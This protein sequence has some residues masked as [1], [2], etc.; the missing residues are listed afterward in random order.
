MEQTITPAQVAASSAATTYTPFRQPQ[1]HPASDALDHDTNTCWQGRD[2][3]P[4]LEM[5]LPHTLFR[6]RVVS[7]EP[8]VAGGAAAAETEAATPTPTEAPA[9]HGLTS[10]ELSASST[11]SGDA[12]GREPSDWYPLRPVVQSFERVPC[13][14]P[15]YDASKPGACASRD[16]LFPDGLRA[17]RL[18]ISWAAPTAPEQP[19]GGGSTP[20]LF[21]PAFEFSS[22]LAVT[23][24]LYMSHCLLI[25]TALV[26]VA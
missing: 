10:F 4:W 23:W 8:L 5:E 14:W 7:G 6:L 20:S 3:S 13:G 24:P 9:R 12:D 11:S 19:G 25:L 26:R 16:L 22:S 17:A 15:S 2:D 21:R 1:K 18:R